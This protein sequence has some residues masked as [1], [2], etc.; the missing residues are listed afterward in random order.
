M[1]ARLILPRLRVLVAV[2]LLLSFALPVQGAR[3]AVLKQVQLPHSYY[4]RE[5]YLPQLTT[6]PSAADFPPDGK[7]LVY[8]MGGSLWRQAIGEDRAT[9]LT[10]GP[11][12]DFQPDVS[13]DGT[14]VVFARQRRDAI[15][16]VEL[17]LAS[18]KERLLTRDGAVAVEPRYSPDGKRIAWVSSRETG[19]FTI[20]IADDTGKGLLAPRRLL[21][22]NRTTLARY[23]YSEY[24]HAINPGWSPDGKRLY[25]V[26][27]RDA[28]WGSGD[29]WSVALDAP[30]DWQHVLRE[31]STWS[32]RPEISP[33]GHRLLYSSYQ[34]RQWHQLW[35][36]TP[37]GDY[38]LPLTFGEFDRRN[39]R[40]SPD[41]ER[42]LYIS[43]ENGNTSL[44]VQDMVGGERREI[45]AHTRAWRRPMTQLRIEL[46]DA[47]GQPLAARLS[48]LASDGRHYAPDAAWMRADDGF[49]R[50]VQEHE[51][52]YFHCAT[53]C[54]L[55]V[56]TGM[57]TVNAS[58]GF[59]RR[60][61]QRKLRLGAADE[62]LSLAFEDNALPPQYGPWI[63]L[64]QHVHMNYGGHYRNTTDTLAGA[65]RAEDLDV[66]YNL[67]VNKEQRVNDIAEFRPG[68]SEIG[69]VTLVQAQEFHSSY[70]GHLGL[71]HLGDHVLTPDFSAYRHTALASPWPHNGV[72]AGLARRQGALVGYVHPFDWPI[73]PATEKALTNTLPA[74][75]ALG[76]VDYMEV[77][78]FA[79]HL[80]TAAVWHRLLNLGY[81]LPAGAGTDAMANYA[82]MRGPVGLNR[83]F[84]NQSG[85]SPA[86][87]A[88]GIQSG[89]S[90][91]SNGPL[92]GF[93]LEGKRPGEVLVRA[94]GG[95]AAFRASLRSGV[96]VDHLEV[97]VNGEPVAR[98]KPDR[99]GGGDFEGNVELRHSGWVLL[100]AWGPSTPLLMDIYPYAS[101]N[102]VWIE[103]GDA[104]VRSPQDAAYFV[105]WLDRT[106]ADVAAREDFN[107]ATEK[108]ATLGYL[109]TARAR[110]E[111]A[112]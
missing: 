112:M 92:L 32:T 36:T 49:D 8:S 25:F 41:G 48:V 76:N 51:T 56:P 80:A 111:E 29:I 54:T 98:L 101:T 59:E 89:H 53:S 50:V 13:A 21:Q 11:G 86:A 33:D 75:V 64:D 2:S 52:H 4:W 17:D 42:V 39:A 3:E 66:L 35:L 16:L 110:F 85:R 102:P 100:R 104:P 77:V 97:L 20:W 103:I 105:A 67:I 14:H 47:S 22:E 38:P 6:G 61:L 62:R 93:T 10:S 96:P 18:S 91:V 44:W 70:W 15:E 72:V 27:N 65:A 7:A 106:I 55:H 57:V 82:S 88:A 45:V 87:L 5:L 26:S 78:S 24:D 108:E 71:L 28:A 58:A 83:L 37:T 90:F 74:D 107:T 12:Y 34:G 95:A 46:R 81:R 31:E 79:D 9:E 23:Y 73:N 40:W 109:R 68:A 19:R 63:S 94:S 69:G 84:L 30:E 43:N 1:A 60:P 99:N